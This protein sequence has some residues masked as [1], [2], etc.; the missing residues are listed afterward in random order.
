MM[1]QA[2]PLQWPHGWPRTSKHL[3]KP[4]RFV[5]SYD[6]ACRK[7]QSEIRMLGGKN[8]VIS[9]EIPIA[10]TGAPYAEFA[11]RRIDD[12]GVAVYFTLKD[13]QRVMA[14][15]AHQTVH[16]NI[17]G[18]AHAIEH[19]RGLERH[20]GDHMMTQAFAGFTALPAPENVKPR[21]LWWEILGLPPNCDDKDMINAAYRVKSKRAHPD[22]GGSVELMHEINEA[23]R[24]AFN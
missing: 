1:A 9:S 8:V 6:R 7:L 21:R 15:D 19:M 23:K 13:Q 14:R 22:A 5:S 11:R 24:E 4:S 16:E 12:P 18:I 10:K 17:M 3:Q 2:Y 20:G